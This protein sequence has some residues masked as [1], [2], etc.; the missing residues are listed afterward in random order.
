MTL[1]SMK[2]LGLLYNDDSILLA[3]RGHLLHNHHDLMTSSNI[4]QGSNA[5]Y[6]YTLFKQCNRDS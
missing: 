3:V 5:A 1:S 2:F 6:I 4:L